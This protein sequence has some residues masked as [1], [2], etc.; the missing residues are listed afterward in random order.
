MPEKVVTG[1]RDRGHEVKVGPDLPQGWG[2][3]SIIAIDPEGMR[4]AAADP[5]VSSAAALGG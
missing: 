3:V 1:L 4:Q 2:P 5:R